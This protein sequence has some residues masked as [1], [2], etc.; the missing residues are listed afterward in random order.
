MS[1][2]GIAWMDEDGRH[3]WFR[4]DCVRPSGERHPVDAMLP[5]SQWRAENGVVTPSIVC[6]QTG[7][8]FHSNPVI[9]QPPSDWKPRA[10]NA[11]I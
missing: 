3:V 10:S 2:P 8:G 9:G 1:Q 4:H 7:C 11:R 6:T 5:H